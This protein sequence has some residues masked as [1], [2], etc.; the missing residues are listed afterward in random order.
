MKSMYE[1]LAAADDVLLGKD[2]NGKE[3]G[4]KTNGQASAVKDE[5][6]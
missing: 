3:G 2:G 6:S 5:G 1:R 4:A